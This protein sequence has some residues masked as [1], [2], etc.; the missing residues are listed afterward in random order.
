MN[1][2]VDEVEAEPELV[3]LPL[4]LRVASGEA[5]KDS[6]AVVAAEREALALGVAL[7]LALAVGVLREVRVTSEVALPE[8]TVE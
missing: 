6:L 3:A 1:V 4:G 5:L 8:A 2:V 7:L